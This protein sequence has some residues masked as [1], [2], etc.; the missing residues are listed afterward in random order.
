MPGVNPR[1]DVCQARDHI[2]SLC[3]FRM[4]LSKVQLVFNQ[5]SSKD[6][7]VGK[8]SRLAFIA[9]TFTPG[10]FHLRWVAMFEI[11]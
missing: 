3:P 10:A 4:L 8:A 9:K 7:T 11:K 6:P 5:E 2:L 1:P